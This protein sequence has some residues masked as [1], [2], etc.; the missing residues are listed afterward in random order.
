MATTAERPVEGGAGVAGMQEEILCPDTPGHPLVDSDD[1]D[2]DD[3]P[4]TE[5]SVESTTADAAPP[6]AWAVCPL[7]LDV[8]ADPVICA[9]NRTY[10][11]EAIKMYTASLQHPRP[12]QNSFL[13][14]VLVLNMAPNPPHSPRSCSISRRGAG[15]VAP[16]QQHE[17]VDARAAPQQVPPCQLD[18]A[19]RNHRGGA[20]GGGCSDR[21]RG[22]WPAGH[23]AV[24]A[25]R[26]WVV[27]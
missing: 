24:P 1:H 5:V 17:P 6:P 27:V 21:D 10:E 22:L 7:T 25:N 4:P 20:H 15:Q 23:P 3:D 18:G 8:M 16:R 9:D 26:L 19:G 11:R 14:P 12:T 2:D 13:C